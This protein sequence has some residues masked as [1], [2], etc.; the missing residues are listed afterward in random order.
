M[1]F[2]KPEVGIILL[3]NLCFGDHPMK[4]LDKRKIMTVE[5]SRVISFITSSI[6]A[7]ISAYVC[8]ASH[9]H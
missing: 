3:D 7:L 9:S 2:A 8:F 5:Q 4:M 6:R 1:F